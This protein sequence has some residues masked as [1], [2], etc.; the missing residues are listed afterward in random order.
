MTSKPTRYKCS[1]VLR[2]GRKTPAFIDASSGMTDLLGASNA[3]F[4]FP[5]GKTL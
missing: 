1:V 5:E 3:N 2:R 4:G